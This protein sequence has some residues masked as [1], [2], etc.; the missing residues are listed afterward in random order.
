M[1]GSPGIGIPVW[2]SP[3]TL[4]SWTSRSKAS[5]ARMPST[6]ATSGP[7]IF[8]EIA[9]STRMRARAPHPDREGPRVGVGQVVDQDLELFD[10][11]VAAAGHAEELRQLADDDRDRE[12]EDEAR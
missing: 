2:I 5:T 7:G 4:T 6:R 1:F 9:R 8:R 10:G 11:A 3:T 12:T